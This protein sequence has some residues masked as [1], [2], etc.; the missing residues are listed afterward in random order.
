MI[1]QRVSQAPRAQARALTLDHVWLFAA[2][3]LVALRAL[4][5]PIPPSDFWWHLAMGRAIAAQG[6]I[7]PVDQFSF[8][9]AGAPFFDQSWLAQLLMYALYQAGGAAGVVVTQALVL[10]LAYGL[11]LRLCVI[12]SGRVN[13]SVALL[14]LS[15]PLVFDNW[16]VRPQSYAFPIFAGFLTVLSE[17]RLGLGRRLW[18][19]PPLMALWVNIHGSFVLGLALVGLTLVG[20]TIKLL[21]PPAAKIDDT[22]PAVSRQS[23]VV[24]LLSWGLITAAAVLLNPRGVS[25]LGYVRNLLG[26][27]AVTGLVTEWAPP[28]IRTLEGQIFFVFAIVCAAVLIY[29]RRRP[30]LTDLLLAGAFFWLALGAGRNVVWLGFVAMPLLAAQAATLLPLPSARRPAG[31]PALNATVVGLL[32]LM[33]VAALPWLKPALF[34]PAVGALLSEDTPV[35]AVRFLRAQPERPRR[36]F[37]SEATG[38]YLL[39]AA[40][41]QPVFI[42]TRIELY[43]IEQWRDYVNLGQGNNVAELL[44]KYAIDGLLLSRESQRPLIDA[45]RRDSAWIERYHDDQTAY[46]TRR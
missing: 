40:P 44:G 42:D 39:W 3:A 29:A 45:V 32:A 7:P 9:Q 10:A 35:A 2:L 31:S 33:L 37:H 20:E 1:E 4:L 21:R 11:L 16:T 17:Y 23:S 30:D 41:E 12:R 34:P 25:V 36:L 15:L 46:F 19:L 18:L 5:T 26:S 24:E 14:L 6:S 28:T 8:T 38:S 27:S 22:T 13:L 43:P